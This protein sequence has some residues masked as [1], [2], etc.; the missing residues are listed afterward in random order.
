MNDTLRIAWLP[1]RAGSL[2]CSPSHEAAVFR[3]KAA[4]QAKTIFAFVE[5]ILD[6]LLAKRFLERSQVRELADRV[7]VELIHARKCLLTDR[8]LI[9]GKQ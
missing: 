4:S 5:P 2:R 9:V 3:G 1:L 6:L 8:L 7:S